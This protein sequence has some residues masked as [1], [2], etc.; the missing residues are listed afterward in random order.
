MTD[1]KIVHNADELAKQEEAHSDL[2]K[3]GNTGFKQGGPNDFADFLK[4]LAAFEEKL[5]QEETANDVRQQTLSE[6]VRTL[7]KAR[8]LAVALQNVEDPGQRER[9]EVLQNQIAVL[10]KQ[11]DGIQVELK[12][13]RQ[14]LGGL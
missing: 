11:R 7:E 8:Q 6:L 13:L 9:R 10:E 2:L 14:E 12:T 4:E 3:K 5:N 1:N